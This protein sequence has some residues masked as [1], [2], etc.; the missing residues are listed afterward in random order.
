MKSC[1]IK[2]ITGHFFASKTFLVMR[3]CLILLICCV[4]Q[5]VASTSYSQVTTLTMKLNDVSIEEVLDQIESQTEFRFLYNK[6]VVDVTRKV[7]ISVKKENVTEILNTLFKNG[8]ISYVISDRYIVLKDKVE[9]KDIQQKKKITGNVSDKSGEPVIGAN[10]V[11]K[12]TANGVI[13][14]IDG[15]FS[16]EIPNSNAILQVS[17]IGYKPQEV[18]AN[19][20]NRID[21][22]LASSIEELN[23]VVVTAMGIKRE[24]KALGYAMQEIKTDNLIENRSESVSNMLQGKVAGV[25]ISQSGTGMG[26]STR[27]IMRGL[28][29]LSGNNQPLWVVDGIP[30]SDN[31]QGE[32]TEWGN[33]D[34]SGGA[35]EINPEDIESISVLK[36]ANA[37]ALYGSRA[38]NGAILVVTKKGKIDQPLTI[39][40]N[41]NVSFSTP[42]ESYKLQNIYGQ[43]SNGQYS[44][45][46]KG[47][48]GPEMDGS[49]TVPNWRNSIYGDDRYQ[50]YAMTSQNSQMMDFY[51][52]GVNYNNSVSLAAGGKSLSGRMAY[53]D[54]R[55]NGVTPSHNLT[56]QY[57]DANLNFSNQWLQV[58]M[59]ANYIRQKG[60]NR[61]DQGEYGIA[62]QFIK[63]PRSIRTVDLENP[64]GLDGNP[65][66]WS[67]A[68]NEY[69]NPYAYYYKGNGNKDVMNRFIGQINASIIFTDWLRLNGK[70]GLDWY[71]TDRR[72]MMPFSYN[73]GSNQYTIY[74][75][76]FQEI[77]S[78]VMLNFNKTF[79]DFSLMANL[80][81]AFRAE[82]SKVLNARSGR[83]TVPGLV[84]ISNGGNKTVEEGF[85]KKEVHSVLGNV[86]FGY[87]SMVYLDL[88]GRNDWSSTLP[89][90]NWSYFYPSVSLSGIISEMVKLPEQI[91]FLKIRGSWAKVGNDTSPYR[92]YPVYGVYTIITPVLGS[93]A[94]NGF[95]L[96]T[97]KPESTNSY[98]AGLDL[99]MFSG[100]IGLDFTY[101]NSKT[102]NQILGISVAQSSGYTTK[103][104]NAGEMASHG[105][106]LMLN[107]IPV[108]TKDWQWDVNLNWGTNMSRC[109]KLDP[110]VKRWDMGGVRIGNV[111]VREGEKFGD[112]IGKAY[113]RDEVGNMK[114]NADGLP[115]FESDKVIGNMMPDW[116]G[117]V[118]TTLRWKD[119]IFNMLIDI[120]HGGDVVSVTDAY[121]CKLGNSERTL[122][123]RDGGLVV[124][125]VSVDTGQPN[126]VAITSQQFYETVGGPDGVAE[127][128]LYDGSYVKMREM[129]V[130]WNLPKAWIDKTPLKSVKFSLVGRDLFFI[131]KNTPSNPEG[132]FSRSDYAQAFEISSM[133]PTRSFGFNLNVKF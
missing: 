1:S 19:G 44:I 33:P 71:D 78:D 92:L 87:K 107:F 72:I 116:T 76:T 63:M 69:I 94:P 95:P 51:R 2:E 43:G 35:S 21:V 65:V 106:E 126:T 32:A 123:H 79:G 25:Q 101:Y 75:N 99:R 17:Y 91:S 109:I 102:T 88:T 70:V 39:E 68:S 60:R 4:M 66:N 16:I 74:T 28:S 18:P 93:S 80:G 103:L 128:F 85:S 49:M 15:N 48:W 111:V 12:G 122:A 47:S 61:P 96:A 113:V 115:I 118:S 36:G 24:K 59:K 53:S 31:M 114:I 117:S 131:K 89:S 100:R 46:A 37:A 121:A 104:I 9:T 64:E 58:G 105:V 50:P 98:E 97:L 42:Y 54:S 83:F 125:G 84:A 124:K 20:K 62:N 130:G 26:G 14:D 22:V 57:I 56:R 52:T 11:V 120:K 82:T 5:S 67:G 6:K 7:D 110:T 127:E 112:I 132:A 10:V 133:P 29:S 30:I 40:Y 81:A 41:G 3:I 45:D 55:N 38:Q 119:V 129:S 86:Q 73:S 108:Q 23:E 13:T 27:V 90:D 34:Y 77:N 8:N